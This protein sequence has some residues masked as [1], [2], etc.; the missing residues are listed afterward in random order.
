MT[1]PCGRQWKLLRTALPRRGYKRGGEIATTDA[2]GIIAGIYRHDTSRALDPNL[3][4]H[5][6][7]ANMVKNENGTYTAITNEGG[8]Q[9][10][11]N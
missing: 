1:G 7:I 2:K 10:P 11:E 8:V 5:A 3:H 9:K 6:V 4:S